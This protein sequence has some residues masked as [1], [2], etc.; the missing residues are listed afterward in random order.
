MHKHIWKH[1]LWACTHVLL[2]FCTA[3]F[4]YCIINQTLYSPRSFY[5]LVILYTMFYN[6]PN[7]FVLQCSGHFLMGIPLLLVSCMPPG[8]KRLFCLLPVWQ[9]CSD[10]TYF[11]Y[12]A[13]VNS[14]NGFCSILMWFLFYYYYLNENNARLVNHLFLKVVISKFWNSN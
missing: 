14:L 13:P 11:N 4:V 6:M 7:C 9:D 5:V 12:Q 3:A 1:I 10:I 8:K 2:L